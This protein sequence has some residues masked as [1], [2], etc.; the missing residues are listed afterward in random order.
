LNLGE[1]QEKEAL[2]PLRTRHDRHQTK[3]RGRSGAS[4]G[5]LLIAGGLATAGFLILNDPD[6]AALLS[7][8]GNQDGLDA[9]NIRP[10]VAHN[11]SF[12]REFEWTYGRQLY[13]WNMTISEAS[14]DHFR[15]LERPVRRSQEN[16][17]WRVQPAYDMYV[18]NPD[19]DQFIDVLAQ[20]LLT[21]SQKEGFS[22]DESLSF[23]LAFVQGLPWTSD[24]VTTGFDE[25]P[26]FP[27]ETLVEGGG[28]CEDTVVLYASLVQAMGYGAI[29]VSP[30]GHMGAG[31]AAAPG[32]PGTV[33]RW[34]GQDYAYAETTGEGYS[35]GDLPSQYEGEK[36]EIYDLAAKPLFSLDVDF[37]AVSRDGYQDILLTATQTGSAP[38]DDVKMRAHV[39]K[40]NDVTYDSAACDLGD[41]EPG[42]TVQCRLRI[43]L[44]KVPRGT[45]VTIRTM[46][47]DPTF[48]YDQADSAAWI[49]RT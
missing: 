29:L 24:S 39:G 33:Y 15:N 14:Y 11:G 27:V 42:A 12:Q 3:R 32:F 18:S 1:S 16:G 10:P 8:P 22:D 5:L 37:G 45:R 44:N 28:D 30:P 41:V 38:A 43:D 49:P 31:V 47:Q 23:A 46:V 7:F 17:V 34:E 21:Q 4:L 20:G 13:T 26:R 19:D 48:V 25:Y 40:T 6:A 36:V 35:I 2:R 9:T